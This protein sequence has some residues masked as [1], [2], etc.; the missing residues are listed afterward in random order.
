MKRMIFAVFAFAFIIG[1]SGN[2][3]ASANMNV[4]QGW[5]LISA[6]THNGNIDWSQST[7]TT[8][9][10][11]AVYIYD[12]WDDQYCASGS[13]CWNN[14][15][16]NHA[17]YKKQ[18]A[19]WGYFTKDCSLHYKSMNTGTSYSLQSGWN[20]LAISESLALRKISDIANDCSIT[21]IYAF[22][23]TNKVWTKITSEYMDSNKALGFAIKVASACTIDTT[24]SPPPLPED[25][26]DNNI[27]DDN[28]GLTDCD[29]PDC[30]NDPAC[31]GP[32]H[33]ISC[34]VKVN[35]ATQ[36]EL[37]PGSDCVIGP[38]NCFV[39]L[40]NQLFTNNK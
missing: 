9:D 22:H 25:E 15:M 36:V 34:Q 14:I 2:V 33:G 32:E 18:T 27:D 39:F 40:R 30:A 5:N 35:S 1:L 16:N 20:F 28:D 31:A 29:D 21:S 26:C 38:V 6:Y 3:F 19:M 23:P 24:E 10:V 37:I 8:D 4:I 11:S 17:T 12:P 13:D 7:C